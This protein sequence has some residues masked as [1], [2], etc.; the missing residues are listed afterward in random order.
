M[1]TSHSYECE[2]RDFFTVRLRPMKGAKRSLAELFGFKQKKHP[3]SLKDPD[4][5]LSYRVELLIREAAQ[6]EFL[7]A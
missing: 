5:S 4:R 6:K 1:G 3:Q 7:R 2:E